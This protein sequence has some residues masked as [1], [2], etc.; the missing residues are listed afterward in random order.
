MVTHRVLAAL[1]LLAA[2]GLNARSAAGQASADLFNDQV[3]QRIDLYVNTRDWYILRARYMENEYY[4]AN[5][6]LNGETV[7]NV[8]IRSRGTGSRSSVSMS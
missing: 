7:T 6:K 5:L 1:V 3:L 4:P 2:A 8:A